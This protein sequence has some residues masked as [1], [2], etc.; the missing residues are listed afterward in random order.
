[1]GTDCVNSMDANFGAYGATEFD[2]NN[3]TSNMLYSTEG[4]QTVA[5]PNEPYVGSVCKGIITEWMVPST[6]EL[7]TTAPANLAPLLPPYYLQAIREKEYSDIIATIPQYMTP[8][9]NTGVREMLCSLK[10]MKPH[11]VNAVAF[12]FGAPTYVTSFPSNDLCQK[13]SK[14][15]TASAMYEY[16]EIFDSLK[17]DCDSLTGPYNLF[18]KEDQIIVTY[19]FGFGPIDFASPPFTPETTVVYET[20]CPIGTVPRIEYNVNTI[21]GEINIV[22]TFILKLF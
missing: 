18:P 4:V 22:N 14:V 12:I 11:P 3:G 5:S 8:D 9:C 10:F 21:Y 7:F 1:M 16:N 2:P 13:Y 15:C 20:Q 17:F 6:Y 19:D